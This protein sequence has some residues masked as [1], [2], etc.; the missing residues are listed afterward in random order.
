[1]GCF[2]VL[3]MPATTL[4]SI[5]RLATCTLTSCDTNKRWDSDPN[6]WATRFVL[7]TN[8]FFYRVA[9][10]SRNL[11]FADAD[12]DAGA[13][14]AGPRVTLININAHIVISSLA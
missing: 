1:M 3:I 2:V 12:A 5:D 14:A 7:G 10:R 9:S 4:A 11:A 8:L 13:G 6:K